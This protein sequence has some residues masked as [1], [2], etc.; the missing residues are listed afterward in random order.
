[1]TTHLV[2]NS[3]FIDA[4]LACIQ[5]AT[6][7]FEADPTKAA[8]TAAV[9]DQVG[10]TDA[11]PT[12]EPPTVPAVNGAD[13][14]LFLR[15][16]QEGLVLE[17]REEGRGD[18][19]LGVRLSANAAKA[20]RPV[21]SG[22]GSFAVFVNAANDVCFIAT[23]GS[24]PEDC[25]GFPGLIGSVAI[26][27]DGSLFG[28]V[29]LDSTGQPDNR[30]AVI[31]VL[32]GQSTIYI[33]A[34]PAI[35]GTSA[36]TVR[37]ADSMDFTSDNRVLIYDALNEVTLVDGSRLG[38]W[39]I[40]SLDLATNTTFTVFPPTAGIDI[41]FPR[42]SRTSD[43]FL[44]FDARDQAANSSTIFSCKL[45]S[46]DCKLVTTVSGDYGVPSYTGDDSAIIYSQGDPSTP[47]GSS[48]MRHR[49]RREKKEI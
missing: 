37:F 9:F 39:S 6:E 4:R 40:Y 12:S 41:S 15:R 19:T 16:E 1:L 32:S 33:L 24:S 27:R 38:V 14:T 31:N 20:A 17:R 11:P 46:G 21:V 18:G 13:A 7:L 30:I 3:Q 29:L 23:D 44:T 45:S 48:L 36:N 49:R 26:S 42:L 47:T 28:L 8:A 10:I 2:R 22:D 25:L 43:D 5:S 34:S 35:D